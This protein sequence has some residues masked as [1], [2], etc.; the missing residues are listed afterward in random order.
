VGRV[1]Q[2]MET[3]HFFGFVFVLNLNITGNCFLKEAQ[4]ELNFSL[5]LK[6]EGLTA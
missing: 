5:S 6:Q 4:L 2:F 1:T 3:A